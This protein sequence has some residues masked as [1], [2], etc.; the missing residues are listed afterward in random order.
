MCKK[1]N[2]PEQ[3]PRRGVQNCQN[4]VCLIR[5]TIKGMLISAAPLKRSFFVLM[6]LWHSAPGLP[7][8]GLIL[9]KLPPVGKSFLLINTPF[10]LLIYPDLKQ[11][12]PWW[13]QGEG[14][15]SKN[16][17][18][19]GCFC[20]QNLCNILMSKESVSDR[21]EFR[22]LSEENCTRTVRVIRA[23]SL[24]SPAPS[25]QESFF[26]LWKE[27]LHSAPGLPDAGL[28][29][30]KLPPVGKSFLLINTPFVLPI[31]PDL[32][33]NSPWC[34]TKVRELTTVSEQSALFV[35]PLKICL[36]QQ[37]PLKGKH[38]FR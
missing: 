21:G 30:K 24:I 31:Y 15:L 7:D 23:Y 28:I 12:S 16:N 38:V 8:A 20:L 11:N 36:Y 25:L 37:L 33:Q 4:A 9:K 29:L 18:C 2:R 22:C 32:K 6:E 5:H 14:G 26:F 3:I 19:S 13:I 34:K 17:R 27:P 1:Q 35:I 10:V